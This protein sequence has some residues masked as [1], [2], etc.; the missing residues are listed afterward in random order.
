MAIC[1]NKLYICNLNNILVYN[2]K[3]LSEKP[4]KILFEDNPKVLNDIVV[5]DNI[6]YIT[7]TDKNA[8]YKIDLKNNDLKPEK[9]LDIPS[10]NG[11]TF[12]KNSIYIASIPSDYKTLTDNN[13][14]Y[15]IKDINKP[16]LEKFNNIPGLYDGLGI[17]KDGNII[18][19]SDWKTS[20]VYAIN[21]KTKEKKVIFYEKGLTPADIGISGN[22][23]LIPD[24][25][26][27]RIIIFDLKTKGK[28]FIQ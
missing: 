28:K 1:K 21:T 5:L 9:W 11:I 8:I 16:V 6:L 23:L 12:Y 22:K 17:S 25:T 13:I 26:R 10:P 15:F 2:L 4:Q 19:A 7:A 24:M 3:S 20:S 18:Y 14:I 27:H